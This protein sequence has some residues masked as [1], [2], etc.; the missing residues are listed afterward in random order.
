VVDYIRRALPAPP[1]LTV[2]IPKDRS[3]HLGMPAK[4]G[5]CQRARQAFLAIG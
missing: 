5:Q 4:R 3:F 2:T 1:S